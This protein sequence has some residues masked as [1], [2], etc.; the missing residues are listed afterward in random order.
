MW[1][2]AG[3]CNNARSHNSPDRRARKPFT[4][5]EHIHRMGLESEYLSTVGK[6]HGDCELHGPELTSCPGA[7]LYPD[8]NRGWEPP[9]YFIAVNIVSTLEYS[10]TIFPPKICPLPL[11]S[12]TARLGCTVETGYKSTVGV[13]RWY[14]LRLDKW[15]VR[16]CVGNWTWTWTCR[17]P[18]CS[19]WVHVSRQM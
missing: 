11:G 16:V 19:A 4:L 8:D 12:N 7:W 14:L 1:W 15:T 13:E 6:C 3:L 5:E 17:P 18:R 2:R 10:H 9:R